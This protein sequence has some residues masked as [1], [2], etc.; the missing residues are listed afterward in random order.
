[1]SGISKAFFQF[2]PGQ[3]VDFRGKKYEITHMISVD[4]VLARDEAGISKRL[5]VESIT[6][7][8]E[9]KTVAE[10]VSVAPRDVTEFSEAEWAQAQKRLQAIKPLLENPMRTR[11]AVEEQAQRFGVNA[12]TLYSWMSIYQQAGS[13]S[14]LV[15][16]KRG[17][18]QGSRT[19]GEIQE[20]IIR[21]T[22]ED[23]YLTPQR[24]LPHVIVDEVDK[25]CRLAK[26]AAPHANTVRRRIQELDPAHVLRKRGR[27]DL[28]RNLYDPILGEFPGADFPLAVVQIDHTEADIILVDEVHRKPIGRPW[29]SVALDI[30]S[31]M[32]HG[33]YPTFEKPSAYSTGMCLARAI[34]PKGDYLASLGVGGEWPI[35]GVMNTLH[36]D[37]GAD[38]RGTVLERACGEYGINLDFRPGGQPHYGG[39]IERIMLTLATEIRKIPGTTFSN[40]AE[41]KGYDSEKHSSMTLREFEQYMVDFIV[42]VYHQRVH[43]S[44]HMSPLRQ[45]RVGIMGSAEA[46]GRGVIPIPADPLR[47]RLDFMPFFHR[48][49][50]QYGV[51]IDHIHYYD[52]ILD[53]YINA[54]QPDN[55]ESK[56]EFMFR[57]DPSDVSKIYFLDPVSNCYVP[58]PYR[59]LGRPAVSAWEAKDALA[60]LKAE[61]RRDIDE[62][63]LFQA[64]DRLRA[65]VEV[66]VSA[67]KSARKKDTRNP[68]RRQAETPAPAPKKHG[69]A[70]RPLPTA[71]ATP[72]EHPPAQIAQDEDI[73]IL[74]FDEYS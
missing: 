74:P 37:N 13:V 69:A 25:R 61:G 54:T 6:A 58:I 70:P 45:F 2:A 5:R 65:R 35:W 64:I 32:V 16:A 51:Q 47:V 50:Q 21:S 7:W 60:K 66:S 72:T 14:A 4:S 12:A 23:L 38:F 46:P 18:K 34:C 31:R 52:P 11:A 63:L 3:F 36:S 67:T 48:T 17:R 26:V 9:P 44:L 42:N 28:A 24:Q 43:S 33:F 62:N 40:I 22:I 29:I 19:L 15:P 8:C 59:N 10:E 20:L 1:M 53:Q 49:I 41:R 39:H 27:P 73:E 56:Q 68:A 57:R 71:S 55:P 30:Y